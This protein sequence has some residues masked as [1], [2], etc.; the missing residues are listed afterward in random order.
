VTTLRRI[1]FPLRL[2]WARLTRRGE[3]V[4]LVALGIA[5][6][7]ALLA[8]VLAGS[9]VAQDRSV[10]RVT[11]HVQAP[12]RTVRL[13]WGGIASG[14]GTDVDELDRTSRRVLAPLV[15]SPARAMLFRTTQA[16]GHLFDLGA[17]DGLSRFV[18]VRTGRLPR[19]CRP[20]HC[21]V[22]QLGG[23]G[24]IPAIA[25]LRLVRVGRAT[26]DSPIPFGNLITRETYASVL[27][28]ALRYHTAPTPPLLLAEGV[29]GLATVEVFTPSYRSYTWTAPI[30]PGDVHPW[31]IESFART[32][33]RARS[34]LAARSLAFDLT[35][36]LAALRSAEET[37]RIAGRR[38]LLIGGEAAALLLAFAVLAATGL[39][40]DAEAQWR[41]LTWYGARRWQL[42]I[43]S[44]AEAVA[45]ALVGAVLGWVVGSAIGA[46]VA[47]EAGA[48]AGAILQHS[49]I[50]GRG[51]VLAGAIA[52]AAA[53]VVLLTLRAGAARLGVLTVTPVDAAAVGA[54]VAAVVALARG[55][56]DAT[57]LA[58]ESGT[59]AVLL[60]LPALIAFVAAVVSARI[61][62]PSLRLLERWGR[63][64]PVALRLAALSLARNP[65]RAAIA[66][67]FLV[68]SLGLALFAE[69]YRA[70][71]ARGQHDQAA[72]VVPV[73]AIVR[74]DLTKLVPVLRVWSIDRFRSIAP[75]VRPIP[76]VRLSGNVRR[77]E[78]SQGFT[79]LGLPAPALPELSWR[80]DY[81]SLSQEEL[82]RRLRLP[83]SVALR[84]VRLPLSGK[85]LELP[86]RAHGDEL[87]VRAIVVTR[88]GSARGIA[89][90]T[91]SSAPLAG[92]IPADARGGLLVSLMFDL[93]GTGLHGVPNAGINAAAVAQG[94]MTIGAP[95]VDGAR[96]PFD[97]ASWTGTGGIS[98]SGRTLRYVVT[99]ENVA[100]F[101][102]R[103]PTDDHPVPAAVSPQLADAAGPGGIL[104]L[105]VGKGTVVARVVGVVKRVPT[106]DG[107]AVLVDGPTL[108]TT[109]AA[110][111]PG[112]GATNEVWLDAPARS[113]DRLESA[114]RRAPFTALS[115]TFRRDVL[116]EL[117]SEPLARG[118][119]ITLAGAALAALVLALVGLLLGVVSDVRDERGEL[120]DLEAQGAAPATLR[121]HLRL[122]TALVALFG[123]LGGLV[124][125]AVLAALIVALVTLTA[126]AGSAEPPLLL[127]FDWPVV[128][129]GLVLYVAAAVALVGGATRRAFRGDV[130]GRFAEVGT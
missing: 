97:F 2:A 86:V 101:R 116:A 39:R 50:A 115:T 100:R 60:V 99:G 29:K 66:V 114:L 30:E 127:G 23:A 118:T 45:V 126:S 90:G 20:D 95:R 42:V 6:G 41:R 88:D 125:G 9:L 34:E 113:E 92:A 17:I 21:E 65:G 61:L 85:R 57:S 40:R 14:P 32:V 76:V 111:A 27:S 74:E 130:A 109:L 33:T 64:G 13:V 19:P 87:A 96:L 119:L 37:G 26:L 54:A 78:T 112:A 59:G 69:S 79:L 53:A 58:D 55:A 11:A 89:L 12:D 110:D 18:H 94:T 93:T 38:L 123:M 15:A 70:T 62:A 68:V 77:L 28:S 56:A 83:G 4:V 10:E 128:L 25:G 36:P 81:S 103:Q 8:A 52:A 71:L 122:R 63:R 82:A 22:V 104:P 72:Y 129:L 1:G 120:F 121:G 47:H 108:A 48:S 102:A 24:P 3:R 80:S 75:G 43:G 51:F 117:R 73:D 44:A 31:T 7:A 35:A 46:L 16:G 124:T 5:A 98:S 49:V 106:V 67:A 107:D 91:T 105:D 84:G